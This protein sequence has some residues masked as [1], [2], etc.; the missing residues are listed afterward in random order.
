MFC[1]LFDSFIIQI[2]E[3][4][5]PPPEKVFFLKCSSSREISFPFGNIVG[6][7]EYQ[8]QSSFVPDEKIESLFCI[9]DVTADC[10][11]SRL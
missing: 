7:D 11:E 3:H 2:S 1:I 4:S 9:P 5:S 8:F 6:L 10:T